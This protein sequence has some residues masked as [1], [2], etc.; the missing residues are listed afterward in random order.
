MGYDC[1]NYI[2]QNFKYSELIEYLELLKYDKINRNCLFY[3]NYEDYLSFSGIQLNINLESKKPHIH[4][5]TWISCSEHDIKY[6]NY[7]TKMIKKRFGG[8]FVSD[9][10]KNRL[11]KNNECIEIKKSEA[12]CYL[13]YQRFVNNNMK[14][15][16]IFYE[17]CRPKSKNKN[18]E[19]LLDYAFNIKSDDLHN[20]LL[21]P[22]IVSVVEDYFRSTFVAILKYL[23]EE[24]KKL[25][26][27]NFKIHPEEL[28]KINKRETDVEN[29]IAQSLNFQNLNI[30]NNNFKLLDNKIN[31]KKLYTGKIKNINNSLLIKVEKLFKQ[32]HVLIHRTKLNYD[33]SD[34]KFLKDIVILKNLV[35]ITYKYL[36]IIYN[37]SKEYISKP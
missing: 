8:Y 6:L 28:I 29:A 27:K 9:Y 26:F 33:Y 3:F 1:V 34:K 15:I 23:P 16:Q 31:L 21:V 14:L 30:I 13:A 24:K 10:G 18:I 25:V 2:N 36:I 37:W 12:G 17:E 7:T 22:F 4:L 11:L 20:N 19:F 5:H 32:R 35:Y